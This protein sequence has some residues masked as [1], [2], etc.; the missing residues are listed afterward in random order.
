MTYFLELNIK[1][2]LLLK[3]SNAKKYKT[4]RL[5]FPMNADIFIFQDTQKERKKL[6]K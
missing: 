4:C 3:I 6:N 2:F 1:L 5:L